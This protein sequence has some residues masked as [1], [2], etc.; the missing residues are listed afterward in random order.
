MYDGDC[1][2]SLGGRLRLQPTPSKRLRRP[3]S[4]WEECT[5]DRQDGGACAARSGPTQTPSRHGH[6]PGWTGTP[7]ASLPDLAG[8]VG[9]FGVPWDSLALLGSHGS[10]VA[11][12][13][14]RLRP[15]APAHALARATARTGSRCPL[16]SVA[17]LILA[18]T[19][20]PRGWQLFWS[21]R[22]RVSQRACAHVED[23]SS[24]ALRGSARSSVRSSAV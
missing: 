21:L 2:R 22:R 8:V 12:V 7:T 5:G 4:A 23:R 13:C 10:V 19:H 6:P 14:G 18:N 1:P 15:K 24:V 11:G 17:R 20:T 9:V 3:A 16:P